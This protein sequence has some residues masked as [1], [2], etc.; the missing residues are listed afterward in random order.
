[1]KKLPFLAVLLALIAL[2]AS[3]AAQERLVSPAIAGFELGHEAAN[4]TQSIREEVP[5]GESVQN[6]SA[7]ITTQRFVIANPPVERFLE[8]FRQSLRQACPA[9]RMTPVESASGHG[10]PASIFSA[11][12]PQSP[13]TGG[14]ETMTVLA[15]AGRDAL[16]VKQVAFR[17]SYRGDRGWAD[18]FL[19]AT[20]LCAG[21]C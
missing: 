14:R 16:H 19:R 5:A 8:G 9:A 11:D 6:W 13:V 3:A 17:D 1:M 12:C 10:G 7:I 21:D 4:A 15:I 2:P 18:G 20:R